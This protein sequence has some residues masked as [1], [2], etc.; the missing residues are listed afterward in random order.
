MLYRNAG[1]KYQD[2]EFSQQFVGIMYFLMY[3]A[4]Y[5]SLG[6]LS[7]NRFTAFGYLHP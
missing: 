3:A 2:V 4:S 7:K 5:V 6:D 1:I